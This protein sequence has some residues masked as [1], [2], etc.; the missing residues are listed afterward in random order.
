VWT[1]EIERIQ[2]LDDTAQ[3]A[4]GFAAAAR[5]FHTNVALQGMALFAVVQPMY[6]MLTQIGEKVGIEDI[7]GLTGGYGGVPESA[8]VNELWAASRERLPIEQLVA[9]FGCHGPV[10]GELSSRVWREDDAPLRRLAQQYAERSHAA[11]VAR[12]LGIPCVVNTLD[13]ST[14]LR[15]GDRIRVDGNKGT[16]EILASAGS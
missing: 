6:D 3:C 5:M 1:R 4:A 8:V 13:G 7:S 12:E 2:R 15:T 16:V 11:V 14:V 10:E 9:R